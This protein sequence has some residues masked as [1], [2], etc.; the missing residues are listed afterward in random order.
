[1]VSN[2]E[3][4]TWENIELYLKLLEGLVKK[5]ARDL[6]VKS[7]TEEEINEYINKRYVYLH[8]RQVS[9]A[10]LEAIK[11]AGKYFTNQTQFKKCEQLSGGGYQTPM[12]PRG[13]YM[14]LLV[15][16]HRHLYI[17]M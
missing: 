9:G 8:N 17:E 5:C 1:M 2:T 14:V 10:I 15:T 12:A 13:P 3:W 11:Y 7:T 4:N 16:P 6:K